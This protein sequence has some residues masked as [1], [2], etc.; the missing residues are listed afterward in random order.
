MSSSLLVAVV[1]VNTAAAEAQV[2]TAPMF[3]AK[4]QEVEHQQKPH[5]AR[6]R[7]RLT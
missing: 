7:E 6:L 5:L 4:T 1:V 3:R 2:A